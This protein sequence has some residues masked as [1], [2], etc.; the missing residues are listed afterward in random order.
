MASSM[1]P[2][3]RRP[4]GR[5]PR[6]TLS[7][8][9]PGCARMSRLDDV[10]LAQRL[11]QEGRE[12]AARGGAGSGWCTCGCCWAARSAP[13]ELGPPLCV[14]FEGWDASGK[15][16]AIQRLVER[17]R[18]P[19]RPGR[20]VRG[21][22]ATTSSGTTSCGGSGRRCPGWGGMA[23]L[24]RTWY[25]RV[26]VERVEGFAP[27][28]AG[29]GPTP[30]SWTSRR[31]LAAEGMIL[32]KF[33]LHLSPEE[34]LRRFERRRERPAQGLEARPGRTGATATSAPAYEAGRR[35]DARAHRH[36]GRALARR[37]RPRTSGSG[38]RRTS[39]APCAR[40]I[41]QAIA[42]RGIDPEPPLA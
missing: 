36:P 27:E 13:K 28:E 12:A 32:V 31:T 42:A 25:G 41:E 3:R 24:D 18:P 14:L 8:A 7:P 16:G 2:L 6:R 39:S 38:P 22:H 15:G 40:A 11:C 9:V 4:A 29:G 37:R 21:A 20:P 35:G 34:Q 26:L 33:W 17:A 1:V 23:V 30:R 5:R 10:D 19:A